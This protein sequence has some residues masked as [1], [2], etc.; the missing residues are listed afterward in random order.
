MRYTTKP[1]A[2]S[3]SS[4][5]DSKTASHRNSDIRSTIRTVIPS[6]PPSW[7]FPRRPDLPLSEM[8]PGERATVRR[9]RDS[10]PDL[11]RYLSQLGLVPDVEVEVLERS[12]STTT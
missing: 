6:H 2:W 9:V 8:E 11:L 4:P 3:T 12:P 1:T 5:K 10:D 7:K